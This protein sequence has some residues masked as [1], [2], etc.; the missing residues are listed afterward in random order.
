MRLLIIVDET[1]FHHPIFIEKIIQKLDNHKLIVGIVNFIPKSSDIQYYFIKNIY[2]LSLNEIYLLLSS[3]IKSYLNLLPYYLKFVKTPPFVK[4]VLIVN[5]IPFFTVNGNINC[6]YYIDKIKLISPDIII[7]SNSQIFSKNLLSIA[8]ICNINRHSSLLPSYK[9]LLPVFH[10][11]AR[12]EKEIGVSIHIM[13]EDIDDGRV[14]VQERI[15]LDYRKSLNELYGDCFSLSVD[16]LVQAVNLI[17]GHKNFK[18][19]YYELNQNSSYF[20]FPKENDWINFRK[21]GGRII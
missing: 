5:K 1:S 16:L 10:A 2:K 13:E 17:S 18:T 6:K 19:L 8:S 21:R 4:S 7:S 9:G 11:Y 20:S 3:K 15:L 14:I 12:G